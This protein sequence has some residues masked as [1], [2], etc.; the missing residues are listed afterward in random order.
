MSGHN[1]TIVEAEVAD[2]I[3]NRDLWVQYGFSEDDARK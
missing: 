1:G 3:P 2:D